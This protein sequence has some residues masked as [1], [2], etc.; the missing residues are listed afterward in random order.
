MDTPQLAHTTG[1]FDFLDSV[2][3]ENGVVVLTLLAVIWFLYRGL[4]ILIWRVWNATM[5]S[6]DREIARL[7]LDRDRYQALVFERLRF[8][9]SLN[10]YR[11]RVQTDES[12]S[13]GVI[14]DE[15][16]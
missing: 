2:R 12:S 1:L 15:V 6:K 3:S 8:L 4:S 10:G 7:I 9:E 11:S 16:H 14:T 5:Q 13:H